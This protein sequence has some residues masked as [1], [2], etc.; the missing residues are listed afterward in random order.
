M[1]LFTYSYDYI[2]EGMLL[3]GISVIED[4]KKACEG[5]EKAF[6]RLMNQYLSDI[7]NYIRFKVSNEADINDII[8]ETMLGIYKGI[9]N[10]KLDSSF[11]TWVLS[12]TRRKIADYYR[13]KYA[14]FSTVPIED[15][16]NIKASEN[17]DIDE[18]ISCLPETDHELL[19]LI[20]IQGLS[21]KEVAEIINVPVGTIK[22]RIY[23]LKEKLKP[24]LM[25]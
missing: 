3:G 9:S 14:E 17:K 18:I 4:I 7:Y 5:D 2:Y 24:L 1:N 16:L 6:E 11:K 8:Q 21:Y 20:F 12:I 10:Y 15:N 22:S 19:N 25:E 13:K 23:Y